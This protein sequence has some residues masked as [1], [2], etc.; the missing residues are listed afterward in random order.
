MRLKLS[1]LPRCFTFTDGI[2]P[3]VSYKGTS[4]SSQFPSYPFENIPW[5]QTPVVT[6]TLALA[7]TS[8]LPST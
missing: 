5:S 1:H 3:T 8:L 6:C 7:H 2:H 4:G